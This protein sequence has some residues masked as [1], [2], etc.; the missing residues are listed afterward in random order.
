M[1]WLIASCLAFVLL[2]LGLAGTPLRGV[3]RSA[4]GEGAYLGLFSLLAL[5]S[6]G[7]MIYFYSSVPHADFI[8]LPDATAYKVTKVILLFAIVLIV[9]GTMTRNPTAV[10]MEDAINQELPGAV[11]ITRHPTQWG[12]LLF[13]T[14]HLIANGDKAS[15]LF[16]GTFALVAFVGMFSMDRRKKAIGGPEWEQFFS[17]TSLI[18]FAA[19]LAGKAEFKAAEL[20]WLAVL[21]GVALYASVYWLH[22]M[23]S[24]GASLF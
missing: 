19:I 2:H 16:F 8:W 22:D 12:I 4:L 3:A 11:K 7:A 14:G 1:T 10:K 23:V 20:N 9:L 24:G 6:L 18:P 17:T 13:A 15:I 21:I 5:S